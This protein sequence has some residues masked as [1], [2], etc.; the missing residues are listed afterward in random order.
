MFFNLF[1]PGT[2]GGDLSRIF[3]LTRDGQEVRRQEL[4][5]RRPCAPRYRWCRSRHRHVRVGLAGYGR[6][7]VVF[8]LCG[9]ADGSFGHLALAAGLLI[10][11]FALPLI[12]R[13]LPNDSH[14]LVGKLRVALQSYGRRFRAIPVAHGAV[15]GVHFLQAWMHLV[16]GKA[17]N[18]DVPFS[19]CLIL[20]PLVGTFAAIPISSTAS[21][22]A[23]SALCFCSARLAF[24]VG[25][26][27]RLWSVAVH[28]HRS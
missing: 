26:R 3:Y 2:V 4:G 16:M 19:F 24:S 9:S 13:F 18:M 23:K 17:L 25:K 10:G 8:R 11:G 27:H 5:A 6:V 7:V 20:Y 14:P 21:A 22:Y 15:V 28:D 12:T 1:A